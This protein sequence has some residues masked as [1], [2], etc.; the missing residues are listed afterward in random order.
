MNTSSVPPVCLNDAAE[1]EITPIGDLIAI[2]ERR[3]GDENRA[4]SARALHRGLGIRRDFT[5]WIK[6]QIK[7]AK[8]VEGE[9]FEEV[10][11]QKGENPA[12]GRPRV[13]YLLTLDAAKHIALMSGTTRG[14]E[15]R[16]YF[17]AVEK[18]ARVAHAG[19]GMSAAEQ[20]GRLE[21][22]R[23]LIE[24]KGSGAGRALGSLRKLRKISDAAC[25]PL[26]ALIQPDLLD[27]GGVSA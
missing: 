17:I 23:E 16:R 1:T 4:V 25:A 2:E 8:L 27:D 7:R 12:G 9:D 3:I 15:V 11:T 24:Q 5:T 26:L 10:Y 22:D 21:R 6:L 19:I 18:A 20:L 14:R 13:D